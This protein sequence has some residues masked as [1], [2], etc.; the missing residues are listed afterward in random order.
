MMIIVQNTQ[1]KLIIDNFFV[2]V[3]GDNFRL[4]PI[5]VLFPAILYGVCKT[6]LSVK[7]VLSLFQN[8]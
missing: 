7:S 6:N 1:K 5:I 3:V 2:K 4:E 8:L